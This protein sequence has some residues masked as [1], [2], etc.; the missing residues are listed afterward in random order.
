MP[1]E[2]VLVIDDSP[3]ILKVVQLVLTKAG[4]DVVL[5]ADGE[6][7]I[8]RAKESVPDLVLLDFVMPKL[9]GYQVCRAFG[10][11][12]ELSR[13]PVVL[14][15]AK[16]DQV[17]ERF[18]KVMGIVDYITKP[19]SPE[20]ITAVVEHT[21]AKYRQRQ[22]GSFTE[23]IDVSEMVEMSDETPASG[24]HAGFTGNLS[25]G[26]DLQTLDL[27]PKQKKTERMR[28]A[29]SAD[30]HEHERE[31]DSADE[32]PDADVPDDGLDTT[33]S[34]GIRLPAQPSLADPEKRAALEEARESLLAALT[35]T[36]PELAA[37][38]RD[39][40][41]L[42]TLLPILS[43]AAKP[44]VGDLDDAT[45]LRG[46]L[47][48]VP[49]VEVLSLLATQRQS[50]LLRI[51][52]RGESS[53]LP[54]AEI[55]WKQGKIEFIAAENFGDSF[56]LGRFLVEQ[57]CVAAADLDL[58]LRNRGPSKKP[59][60]QQLQ[61]LGYLTQED[62]RRALQRQSTERL[63][64]VLRWPAGRF[65]FA[66]TRELP[67]LALDAALQLEVD[68]LLMEGVRRIDEWH[69]IERDIDDFDAV[70]LRNEEAVQNLG[71]AKLT[72]DELAVLELTNGK[73]SVK[74]II[75]QSRLGSFEVSKMLYRLLNVRLVR[76][77]VAPVAVSQ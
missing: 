73:N 51:W 72:R 1:G 20:A 55:A 36:E 64:E 42:A 62:L 52:K 54:R 2:R 8:E 23:E 50:G 4:Y 71:R 60:G 27:G 32:A 19:F 16:G 48:P 28:R 63:Y 34:R 21:L 17:G 69:L 24:S 3:T 14:M 7:G 40:L 39:R 12:E 13:V 56:L 15:S 47:G 29:V 41:D 37:R 46:S 33:T 66:A 59:I 30:N 49:I 70:F 5:A 57:R 77:K 58:F 6:E 61:K 65:A 75:K 38:L 22:R 35:S 68:G 53:E 76:R 26:G 11:S 31:H 43:R 18:V 74:E 25:G 67:P 10:E 44:F 9:N 45:V